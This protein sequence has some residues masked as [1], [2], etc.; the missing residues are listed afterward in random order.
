MRKNKAFMFSLIVS[1]V[2]ASIPLVYIIFCLANSYIVP[3]YII[4]FLVVSFAISLL[5]TLIKKIPNII[6]VILSVLIL[7]VT[8]FIFLFF[9]FFGVTVEFR[10]FDGAKEINEYYTD[11]DFDKFG[12]YE[13]ISNYKYH[14][15]SIFQQEAYTTI[16]KYNKENFAKEK[17]NIENNY[18]FYTEPVEKE[19]SEPIFSYE[20]FDFRVEISDWYPKELYLIGINNESCEIAYVYFQDYDLDE[21]SDFKDILDYYCGWRYVIKERG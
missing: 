15:M 21:V 10:A 6:K 18:R 14:A 7:L 8:L 5:L 3:G 11:F 13:S 20:D 16:L 12:E 4:L 1:F 19:G 2:I 9:S 17:S